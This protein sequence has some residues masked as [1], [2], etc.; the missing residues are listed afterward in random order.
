[1]G[2]EEG[3]GV[4]TGQPNLYKQ[5]LS[6][7]DVSKLTA[8][9]REVISRQATINIGT[10]G[11]VAHG[12]S[13]I[14]K[15]ISGVQTVRFKN[16]LERNITI[17]LESRATESNSGN[18]AEVS[19]ATYTKSSVCL[20]RPT[21]PT[22][23]IQ[24][25]AKLPR[26]EVRL[27][28][29]EMDETYLESIDDSSNIPKDRDNS[30]AREM[31]VESI[32]RMTEE[33]LNAEDDKCTRGQ[34][35]SQKSSDSDSYSCDA[36]K[37]LQH[38]I[39]LKELRIQVEDI[40]KT[41]KNLGGKRKL[42]K[43]K[44]Y[45]VEKILEKKITKEN[46]LYL[47]KWKGWSSLSNTWEPETNLVDCAE[48]LMEFENERTRLLNKFKKVTGFEPN[49]ETIEEL[50]KSL[51]NDNEND[52]CLFSYE[53][54]L[55]KD[56]RKY[57]A[58]KRSKMRKLES[59]IKHNILRVLL[60]TLRNEQLASLREWEEEM[61]GISKGKPLIKVENLVDLEFAPCD[62]Y[63]VD[64]Y[65]PGAGVII[66]DEPPIGCECTTCD[67]KG[68][69]CF[70][71]GSR[72]FSYTSA[73]RIRVPPGTPIYECN[74]RCTCPPDC[75][76]RVVQRGTFAKLCV[77]RTSNGRGWGVKTLRVI[78]KGTFV[79]Q[80]VGEVITSEEAEK[81]GTEYDAA[82]R[83]YLFDLDYNQSEDQCLYTVDAAIYGNVSHFIN[84]SCDPNLAVYAVWIDC[85]EPDLP[86]L[87]LFATRDIKQNEEIT[88]DYACQFSKAPDNND[89]PSESQQRLELPGGRSL[90]Y[91][92][93]CKCGT[94]ACRQYLF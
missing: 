37:Y 31:L 54:T 77:F 40:G 3:L 93:R 8:L 49:T 32:E 45:E 87:A 89:L 10:I 58:Q 63:Y 84:H 86:K 5:D 17:K 39:K 41:F 88:F 28:S 23:I 11:H 15:A 35:S 30:T 36:L 90:D 75:L 6:K 70:L 66:P 20:K 33:N 82:G 13:T 64:E 62:F 56:L 21:S 72:S 24:P 83:T 42:I 48:L 9:S 16:E 19:G 91:K 73:R 1:M 26:L 68:E 12:K 7:L 79:T 52:D 4:T 29:I 22:T 65:L 34:R 55:Y 27:P 2:G 74:K 51:M 43:K 14:V 76:N 78:K 50:M 53:Y 81:R 85:L 94:K 61:N 60:S 25:P 18:K 57:F 69:C 80:Y 92:T 38:G 59:R 44:E 47:I 71:Q 46:V 67:S